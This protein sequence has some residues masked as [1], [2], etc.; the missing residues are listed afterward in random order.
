MSQKPLQGS[1]SKNSL[2]LAKG[3]GGR[4]RLKESTVS[5]A[6]RGSIST[7]NANTSIESHKNSLEVVGTVKQVDEKMTVEIAAYKKNEE[8]KREG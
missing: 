2:L 7:L 1:Q 3:A 4:V 8:Q 6:K 5:V